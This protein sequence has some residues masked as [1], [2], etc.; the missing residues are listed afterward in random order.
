MR[1]DQDIVRLDETLLPQNLYQKHSRDSWRG[2]DMGKNKRQKLSSHS[3]SAKSKGIQKR[4]P[5]GT[6]KAS[7][8]GKKKHTQLQHSKPTI[9][10][11]PQ[12]QILLIGEGDLSFTRSLVESHGCKHVTA[13]VL[14]TQD[15][16]EAKYPHV[17]ENITA[18]A[19][20]GGNVRYGVDASKPGPLW[21][22]VRG[23][24]DRVFF[25]FPHVGGKSTDVN[26]QVR[27]NQGASPVRCPC[28]KFQLT[29]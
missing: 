6:T 26:R 4:A 8:Q 28:Y 15:E 13:T 19:A 12:N 16:L 17:K 7:Q 11:S 20:A 22:D 18:I 25:N 24:M 23:K 21:R 1:P 10:F 14:E 3:K 5:A 2:L 27:Y 29:E 9:P